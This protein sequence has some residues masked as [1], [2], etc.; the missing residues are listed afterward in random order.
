MTAPQ[1]LYAPGSAGH[2]PD[3]NMA[4][5]NYYHL[6]RYETDPGLLGMFQHA[7]R[8][9]WLRE[10]RERNAFTNFVYAAC[11]SGKSRTDQW[12]TTDLSP[13]KRCMDDAIDTLKRF[14]LDLVEW[15]MSNAHRTDMA[16]L[17]D[18]NG[19]TTGEGGRR[20]GQAFPI[21]ERHGVGWD[22]NPWEL[23]CNGKG[24]RLRDGVPYLLAYYMGRAHGFIGD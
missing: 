14:P 24:L 15:P 12:G 23:T 6:L 16:P 5:M 13:P 10:E 17:R 7:V 22:M 3:D 2:Q 20:D 4:F 1:A 8:S 18:E 9:H 21:D 11:C 19:Q